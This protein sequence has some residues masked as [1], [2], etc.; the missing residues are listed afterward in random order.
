MN[1]CLHCGEPVRGLVCN[2]YPHC[3]VAMGMYPRAW[4]PETRSELPA[5]DL[6]GAH[7]ENHPGVLPGNERLREVK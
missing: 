2:D 3:I 7:Q 4:G 1:R 5:R 6:S